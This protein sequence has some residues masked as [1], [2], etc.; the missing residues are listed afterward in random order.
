MTC[1]FILMAASFLPSPV[2]LAARAFLN[3]IGRKPWSME[4]PLAPTTTCGLSFINHGVNSMSARL[5]P[6]TEIE[7][8]LKR[9]PSQPKSRLANGP[10]SVRFD[11]SVL[12]IIDASGVL[13]ELFDC[14]QIAVQ[15]PQFPLELFGLEEA[16][17]S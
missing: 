8:A 7:A 12:R 9:L 1:A 10:V 4:E 5:I 16:T 11:G 6:V 14:R 3:A 17:P 13:F 2:A 15:L